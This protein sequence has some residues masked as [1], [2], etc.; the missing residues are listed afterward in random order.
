M[1]VW[2]ISSQCCACRCRRRSRRS[3][4]SQDS[5]W[6]AEHAQRLCTYHQL[7][8]RAQQLILL[9]LQVQQALSRELRL[10]GQVPGSST[11]ASGAA[12]GPLQQQRQIQSP[13]EAQLAGQRASL[14][15]LA[16]TSPTSGEHEQHLH[17]NAHSHS[18]S[19]GLTSACACA[20]CS[21][22]T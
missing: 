5:V 21:L 8:C 12:Q 6:E 18:S 11:C 16:W 20:V 4:I 14:A 9:R 17:C 1:S 2:P 19:T 22:M 3:T 13:Q 15:A 7:S 10:E